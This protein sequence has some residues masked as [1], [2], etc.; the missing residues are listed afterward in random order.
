MVSRRQVI[1][2]IVGVAAG[3]VAAGC[4]SSAG[5]DPGA[6]WAD[7]GPS[8]GSS[9]ANQ[10]TVTF[11]PAADTANVVPGQPVVVTTDTGTLQSVTVAAGTT[12]LAGAL[13]TDQRTWRSTGNLAYGKTYVITAVV[14][15]ASGATAQKTASFTTLKP[16]STASVTFQ[17]NALHSL[18]A[19]GTYGMGQIPIVR[20][21]RSV[22]DRAAAEKAVVV[23]T[24]PAVDG[25]FFWLDKQ[26]LH[27]R[28][29]KYF[30][31]GSKISIAVNLLGVNLGNNVYGAGNASTSYNIGVARLAVVDSQAHVVTV[32]VNGAVVRTMPCSTGKNAT[33]TAADGHIV[34][35]NTNSGAHVVLEKVATVH[36]SSASYGI[37]DPKDPNYYSEDVALCTRISYSGEYLHSAPWNGVIGKANISHGCVNL[38]T[39]DAQ[40]VYDTFQVGDVVEVHGTPVT[41][42]IGNGLGDWVVP[43]ASYGS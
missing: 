10:P 2:G 41:L 11:A 22:S 4:T 3:T 26:T 28:P 5:A 18:N 13:D 23:Q 24:S 33:T 39:P 19:G 34:N 36:M 7:P 43:Y 37:T 8:L 16:G 9:A 6:R 42:N 14:A 20:F 27:W 35:Y 40:W 30:A 29:E 12:T 21:S 1:T 38:H 25:K 31:A 15:D 32:Y 17:A